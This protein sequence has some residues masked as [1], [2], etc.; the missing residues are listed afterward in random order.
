MS[1]DDIGP[2]V[3]GFNFWAY[4]KEVNET[5]VYDK[6][7]EVVNYGSLGAWRGMKDSNVTKLAMAGFAGTFISLKDVIIQA[8]SA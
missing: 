1:K 3:V 2:E 8:A 6:E 5:S 4:V 7:F